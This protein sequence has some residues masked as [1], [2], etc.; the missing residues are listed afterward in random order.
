MRLSTRSL[1]WAYSLASFGSLTAFRNSAPSFV[2]R[3]FPVLSSY[4]LTKTACNAAAVGMDKS[5]PIAPPSAPPIKMAISVMVGW[6]LTE[7]CMRRGL[8]MLP[9]TKLITPLAT[10]LKMQARGPTKRAR[11]ATTIIEIVGPMYGIRYK[12]AHR[13]PRSAE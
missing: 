2:P 9:T 12:I 1:I 11:A 6:T 4:I 3:I 5:M 8:M 13:A 10:M 7:L